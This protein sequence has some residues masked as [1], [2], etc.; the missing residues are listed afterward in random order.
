LEL[1]QFMNLTFLTTLTK[2]ED[3]LQSVQN[4]FWNE[5]LFEVILEGRNK[6]I[7]DGIINTED[8]NIFATY[9]ALHFKWVLTW[10]QEQDKNWKIVSEKKFYPFQWKNKFDK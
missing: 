9:W 4:N 2:N 8:K 3:F 5:L 7:V 6:V 10:L 1:L